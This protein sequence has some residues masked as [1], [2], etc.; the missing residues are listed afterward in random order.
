MTKFRLTLVTE[1]QKSLEKGKKFAELIC[2]T[3]NCKN[4]FEI[5]K[6]EKFENS[7]RIEIIGQITDKNSVAE[8]IELTDRICSPWIV[9]YDRP[10]NS[11]ELIF[12]KSDFCNFRRAEFNVLNWA[13]FKT[14]NE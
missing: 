6:Y 1:N 10:K 3:L 11:V 8:S 13:N 4:R 7:Y 9:T 14:E 5:S 12:N 2:G